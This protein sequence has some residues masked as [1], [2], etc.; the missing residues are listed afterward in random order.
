LT[1]G[2][3]A[4]VIIGA[5]GSGV[6]EI[7]AKPSLSWLGQRFLTLISLGS[8]AYRDTAYS[9]AATDPT[10]LPALQGLFILLGFSFMLSISPWA[11]VEMRARTDRAIKENEFLDGEPPDGPS[12]SEW[13]ASR[14]LVLEAKLRD[15]EK[16][17][18]RSHKYLRILT[19]V[20]LASFAAQL[21][22][23]AR[24][25]Q[26]VLIWRTFHN[27]VERLTP[28]LTDSELKDLR[29]RFASMKTRAEYRGI[30]D[31]MRRIAIERGRPLPESDLW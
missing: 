16:K 23:L 9:D 22:G 4:S 29:M 26:S 14:K 17:M 10:A 2:F 13:I 31:M 6:W 12:R 15:L 19:V 7:A 1:L 11:F 20:V 21:T 24:L 30:D 8:E 5:I 3:A 28:V 27:Q 25:N 18:G